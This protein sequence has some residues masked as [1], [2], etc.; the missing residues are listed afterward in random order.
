MSNHEE[1]SLSVFSTIEDENEYTN[2]EIEENIDFPI[3][4]TNFTN[5][6]VNYKT[7]VDKSL[8]IKE[9]ID[10]KEEAMM[11]LRPTG[12]GKTLNL[13]FRNKLKRRESSY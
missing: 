11:M 10:S 13:N 5:L 7:F 8:F 2:V 9:I 3:S 6:V 1:M 4:T 12:F